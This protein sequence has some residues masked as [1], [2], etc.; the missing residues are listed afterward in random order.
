LSLFNYND[1]YLLFKK[2]CD[3]LLKDLEQN[4]SKKQSTEIINKL[5]NLHVLNKCILLNIDIEISTIKTLLDKLINE[6]Q[7]NCFIFLKPNEQG[8][9]IFAATNAKNTMNLNEIFKVFKEH[10]LNVKGGGKPNYVQ[11]GIQL[12]NTEEK[13]KIFNIIINELKF[14]IC[15]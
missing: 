1:A 10:N 13:E 9:Q 3:S 2:Y 4:L 15:E 14:G 5:N 6:Q 12:S 11:G 8:Y 7:D